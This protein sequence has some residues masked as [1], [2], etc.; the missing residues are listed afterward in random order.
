MPRPN[1]FD[2]A[3]P[4]PVNF[5]PGRQHDV[6]R[7]AKDYQGFAEKCLAMAENARAPE[8]R[9]A[10]ADM[11]ATWLDRARDSLERDSHTK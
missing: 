3:D 11:A 2:T 4:P 10:F 9:K 7:A 5:K 8:I 1:N 6:M